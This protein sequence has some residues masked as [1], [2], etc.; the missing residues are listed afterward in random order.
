MRALSTCGSIDVAW[1]SA[2]GAAAA[3]SDGRLLHLVVA[4]NP[5]GAPNQ[6]LARLIDSVVVPQGGHDVAQVASTVFPS[7]CYADPHVRYEPAMPVA[8]LEALDNAAHDLY[9]RYSQMLPLL[10]TFKGNSHGTYF[11]RLVSWPGKDAGGYNQLETRVRQLRSARNRGWNSYNAADMTVDVEDVDRTELITG[12]REYAADDLRIQGF[13]C[14]VHLD[15][16]VLGDRLNLMAVYR[17]WYLIQKAYGNLIGL[18]RLQH[19]LAQQTGYAVGELM[20]HAAVANAELKRF[21]RTQI[22]ELLA[23]AGDLVPEPTIE[24]LPANTVDGDPPVGASSASGGG[25][26]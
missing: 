12:L 4:V 26:H 16:S 17:H 25:A 11:G 8:K 24:D 6:Q 14:L 10:Q 9:D 7:N 3:Q 15:I 5:P 23:Q 1:T 2:L 18:S 13:P 22:T 19:F 20:V 21:S